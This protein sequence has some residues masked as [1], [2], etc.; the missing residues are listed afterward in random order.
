MIGVETVVVERAPA[1]VDGQ[2]NPTPQRDWANATS[3]TY[4]GVSVQPASTQETWD[5][6]GVAVTVDLMLYTRP[7]Q[8]VDI[9]ADD[10]VLW[11]GRTLEVVGEP[12]V[13]K[14]PMRAG[15]HHLEVM[16]RSRPLASSGARGVAAVLADAAGEA[17]SY[18][19]PWTP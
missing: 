19:R 16:L 3:T 1:L 8:V 5:A 7:G 17:A 11:D 10:R 9:R 13:W 15:V 6:R 12:Q 14:H 4:E 18:A 2:G